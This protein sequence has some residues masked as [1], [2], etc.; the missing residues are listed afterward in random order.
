MIDVLSY[1]CFHTVFHNPVSFPYSI[2]QFSLAT[3]QMFLALGA[4]WLSPHYSSTAVLKALAIC[5]SLSLPGNNT[6]ETYPAS[7]LR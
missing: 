3:F 1:F 6:W 4:Y 7:V 2:A 5:P